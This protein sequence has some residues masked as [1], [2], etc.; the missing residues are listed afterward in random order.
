[1]P[2]HTNPRT[3][4]TVAVIAYGA[5]V[6]QASAW[7]AVFVG[8]RD[9]FRLLVTVAAVAAAALTYRPARESMRQLAQLRR[10][11]HDNAAE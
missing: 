6:V 10:T 11:A 3:W 8:G 1:M 7:A 4:H 2:A 9:P 5:L